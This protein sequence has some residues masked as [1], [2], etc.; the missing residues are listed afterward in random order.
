MAVLERTFMAAAFLQNTEMMGAIL[1]A[2]PAPTLVVDADGRALF[3]NKSARRALAVETDAQYEAALLERGGH[4]LH[5]VHEHDSPEGCGR[6]EACKT[7]VVRNSVRNALTT[8]AVTRARAVLQL[9]TG[10]ST[11]DAHF[12]VS[13][14]TVEHA[15]EKAV[16]LTLE[17]ISDLVKL[18]SLLPICYQCRK[19]RSEESYWV[20]VE[21]YLK[22][23]AD[24]E[25][26]H[27]LCADCLEKHYPQER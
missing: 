1:D 18:T 25:F 27:C 19:V 4:L 23:K 10:T 26:S 14:A 12:L 6:G 17:D 13:T 21:D 9:D 11:V 5:C 8:R 22:Q 3:I 7:C 16:I 2:Y 15:G 24:I 20:T